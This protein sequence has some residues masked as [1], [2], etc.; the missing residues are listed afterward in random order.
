V[1]FGACLWTKSCAGHFARPSATLQGPV[2]PAT[3]GCIYHP[4]VK[5]G[6]ELE[7]NQRAAGDGWAKERT[8]AGTTLQMLEL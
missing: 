3:G 6:E 7:D 1:T 5:I 2:F 8:G 4:H